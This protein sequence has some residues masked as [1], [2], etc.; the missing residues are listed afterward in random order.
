LED[1]TEVIFIDFEYTGWNPR[2]MDIANYFS[3]TMLDNAHPLK[4]GIKYYIK[5]FIKEHE[6]EFLMKH[7][8]AHYY[9]DY[10]QVEDKSKAGEDSYVT[11]EYPKFKQEVHQCLLLNNFFWAIWSLRM[12][13]P[14]SL[15]N[16]DVFN[17]DFAEARVA[18]Y[19]HVKH[20]YHK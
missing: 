11:S 12:L 7:Y 9:W 20:L 15:G 5:N 19:N 3:E 17:F 6:Q 10:H 14:E 13:K 1:A 8:L 4:K 2:A 18:M 16:P